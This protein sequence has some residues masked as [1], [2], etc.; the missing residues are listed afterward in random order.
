MVRI[1]RLPGVFTPLSDTW[2]L[3]AAAR[4]EARLPGGRVLDLCTGSGAVAISAALAG[5]RTVTAVDV[6]RR[7][8]WAVRLNARLNG[9]RVDARHGDLLAAVPGERF[10][11][12][13]AN[14]PYLPEARDALP[15]GRTAR[16]T[17][18]GPAGRAVLDRI[19]DAAPRH[20][21]PGGV[22]LVVHSSVNG[23]AATLER[24]RAAGLDGRVAAR[25]HG[26]LGP[27]LAARAE[28]LEARGLLPAGER[29]EDLL[30][31]RGA[32]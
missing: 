20:L 26:P 27:L 9:V 13:C 4:A 3:A 16:H 6:S 22:L 32:G 10:D 7:A 1:A 15:R 21:R 14:P 28:L 2:L 5:A 29:E 11:V 17:E 19:I 23:E 18:A 8:A 31:V 12:I 25:R 30:V 24:M